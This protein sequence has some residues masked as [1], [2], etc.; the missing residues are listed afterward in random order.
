MNQASTLMNWLEVARQVR[1]ER[2]KLS[3]YRAP[4]HCLRR[5]TALIA[6]VSAET[7]PERSALKKS[8]LC[9]PPPLRSSLEAMVCCPTLGAACPRGEMEQDR[10]GSE[11]FRAAYRWA[12]RD[13]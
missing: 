4:R 13:Q 7:A 9:R 12:R 8:E 2:R 6:S 5:Q 1:T 10:A 11:K 3:A